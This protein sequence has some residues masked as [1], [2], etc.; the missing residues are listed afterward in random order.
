MRKNIIIGRCFFLIF[1]LNIHI[2]SLLRKKDMR[3]ASLKNNNISLSLFSKNIFFHYLFRT[4]PIVLSDNISYFDVR[5][6]KL[7]CFST[8][9]EAAPSTLKNNAYTHIVQ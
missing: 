1:F 4:V 6:I 7:S 3:R 2:M 9:G 8:K 5:S